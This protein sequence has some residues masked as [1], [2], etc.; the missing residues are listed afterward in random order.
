MIRG[1]TY[2]KHLFLFNLYHILKHNYSKNLSWASYEFFEIIK[3][4]E[5]LEIYRHTNIKNSLGILI[6]VY[7]FCAGPLFNVRQVPFYS[8]N[9]F[10]AILHN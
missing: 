9:E 10:Y 3:V 7:E 2:S 5:L 1:N 8:G 4:T 6:K